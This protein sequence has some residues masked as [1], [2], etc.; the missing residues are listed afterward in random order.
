M[1]LLIDFKEGDRLIINGAVIENNG[2]HTRILV[3]N[4][5]AILRGK[6]VLSEE[7]SRTPASRAYF[8]L[9]CAYIF[10]DRQAEYLKAFD[11][12]LND[13][14]A[15]CPSAMSISEEIREKLAADQIYKAM[16]SAQKLIFHENGVLKSLEG[17]LENLQRGDDLPAE[18]PNDPS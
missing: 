2:A 6:E 5:A 13:Y 9:Q 18:V 4:Q 12:Y 1:P 7:E 15:A 10:P 14:I 11:G 3:H 17:D 16:K 8:A